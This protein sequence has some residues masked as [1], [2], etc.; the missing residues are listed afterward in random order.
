MG[1][2]DII[3]K[4]QSEAYDMIGIYNIYNKTVHHLQKDG[5]QFAKRRSAI[6]KGTVHH[7]Q[8]ER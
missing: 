3:S 5:T 4:S 2:L 7:L 1:H 6:Y 8:K